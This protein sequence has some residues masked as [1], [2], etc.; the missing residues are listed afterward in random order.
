MTGKNLGFGKL[1][2]VKPD[3]ESE[4]VISD[5]KIDEIGERHGFV[6]E[7]LIQGWAGMI[8]DS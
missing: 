2:N 7:S 8:C 3:I 6:R 5:R 1:A 4:P